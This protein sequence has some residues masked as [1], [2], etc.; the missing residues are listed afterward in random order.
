LGD[1]GLIIQNKTKYNSTLKPNKIKGEK[2]NLASLPGNLSIYDK[3]ELKSE[4]HLETVI[5]G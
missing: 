4:D 1:V 2:M 5:Q 3:N